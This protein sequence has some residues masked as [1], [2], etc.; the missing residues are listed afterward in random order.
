M[1][2]FKP[3]LEKRIRSTVATHLLIMDVYCALHAPNSEN[4]FVSHL[5]IL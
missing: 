2:G 1:R 5:T 3:D 4:N